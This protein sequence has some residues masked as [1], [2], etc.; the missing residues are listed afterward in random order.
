MLMSITPKQCRAARSLLGWTSQHLSKASGVHISTLSRFESGGDAYQSTAA[1]LRAELE[2]GGVTFVGDG[3]ASLTG[4]A[5]V[6]L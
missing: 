2:R 6:R 5:G 4:G 3:E 1:K